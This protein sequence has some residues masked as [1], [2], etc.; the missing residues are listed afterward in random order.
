MGYVEI[1]QQKDKKLTSLHTKLVQSALGQSLYVFLVHS[2]KDQQLFKRIISNKFKE[3]I[4]CIQYPFSDRME[5]I[6]KNIF[7][8]TNKGTY[9]I[10]DMFKIRDGNP[11]VFNA[12]I[13]HSN[14]EMFYCY[15]D[16]QRAR[17]FMNDLEPNQLKYVKNILTYNEKRGIYKV[18]KRG[19]TV[20]GI[21]VGSYNEIKP[22]LQSDIS[23]YKKHLKQRLDAERTEYQAI[24]KEVEG[25]KIFIAEKERTLKE[26]QRMLNR[27]NGDIKKMEVKFERLQSNKIE[28]EEDEEDN[29]ELNEMLT[30]IINSIEDEQ[31]QIDAFMEEIDPFKAKEQ[32]I[33]NQIATKKR[34]LMQIEQKLNASKHSVGKLQAEFTEKMEQ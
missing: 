4:P 7:G 25:L 27:L 11:W 10:T 34:E 17:E 24:K 9:R 33:C 20:S 14:A 22:I 23:E 21:S 19:G 18:G 32:E 13:T 26:N 6:D 31:A 2:S 12:I 29:N 30:N 1:I 3:I 8:R 15:G 5:K 28:I 16:L